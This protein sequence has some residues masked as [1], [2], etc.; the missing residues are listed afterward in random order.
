MTAFAPSLFSIF[1][2][3]V[4]YLSF[5]RVFSTPR[6]ILPAAA[7][8]AYSPKIDYFPKPPIAARPISLYSEGSPC[9]RRESGQNN[10]ARVMTNIAPP[11]I[12]ATAC[13]HDCPSTCALEVEKLG[14]REI[15]RVRGAED[16]TYT[17]GVIC[18]KVA[19][20]AERTHH[21]DRLMHPMRRAGAKGSGQ[22]QQI[23][24]DDAL[25]EVA[26]E[27]LKREAEYGAETIWPYYYAGTMGLVQRDGINR[28][29]HVKKYSRQKSTICTML[30]W[31]G[32]N[33]GTGALYGADPREMA[34]SDLIVIWGTNAVHTQIN[35][36][37]HVTRARK[38]RN[39]KIVVIDPYRNA[40]AIAAD[41]HLCLRPGTDGA[42]ACAVMHILFAEGMADRAYMEKYTKG[43]RELEEHLKSRTPEWAAGITGLSVEE[44]YDFARA[45]GQTKRA[46]LRLG[47]G[48]SRSRN[49]S[50]NMHAASCLAAVSGAWQYEGGGAFH[51]NGAMYHWDKTLIEGLDAVDPAVRMLDMSRIGPV[52]TGDKRDLGDGPPVTGLLIQNTNPM[53]VA[54]DLAKVHAGFARDDLFVCVHEQFMTE[55]AK[56]ADIIL[57]AT[58]FVEHDDFYQGG[59]QNH[60]MMGGKVIEPLG[61]CR[62]NHAVICGLAKRLGARHRGFEMTEM[63]I[64]DE[65]LKKSGW[66]DARQLTA[67]KWH[68]CQLPFEEAHYLGGFAHADKRFHFTPDWSRM[69]PDFAE[70][71]T[72]PDHWDVIDQTDETHP[73][74][75]VTAPAR[76]FLNSSFTA[77]PSSL[78]REKRPTVKMHSQDAAKIGTEDGA[79]VRLG[80]KQGSLLLH[81]EV[82][83]GVQPGTVISEG[84][85]PSKHFI[86]KIGINILISADAAKPN[87]GAVFHDTAVWITAEE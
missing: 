12:H 11:E 80:N 56:M 74:R 30:A 54:P 87:G 52:L 34:K 24:W 58:T 67:S 35:V 75:L 8:P 33:V 18:A 53:D 42:L 79:I 50:V 77:T 15:G 32:W 25:D 40:T 57:P 20:Y 59:G 71:P 60:I 14:D 68:D 64:I 27:F 63:E 23:S 31:T 16:N 29:R 7:I 3:T 55:T 62:S 1:L 46:Y 6:Y 86:E 48:F 38:E 19:R 44:I 10:E 45:Y 41:I 36:M 51:N 28:L 5:H 73:Y 66:P 17:A 47:Y 4:K 43:A 72:L 78:K 76:N 49:G 37:T 69:G 13:P 21:P 84:V 81:A 85:W 2:I 26:E 9:K 83:D 82:F 65:T 39:A 70:M 61:E 22:W